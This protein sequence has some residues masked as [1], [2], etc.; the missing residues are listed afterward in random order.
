MFIAPLLAAATG[1]ILDNL[2]GSARET[3]EQFGVNAPLFLS[4]VISFLIVCVLLQRFAYR[5][6]L[7]VLEM[8]RQRIA[9]SMENAGKIQEQLADAE[10]KH[11][12]ILDRAN[13]EAQKMINEAREAANALAATREQQAIAEAEGIIAQAREAMRLE[14]DRMLADLRREVARLVVTTTG[15]VTGK[16]LT[17]DDQRRLSEEAAREIA[18]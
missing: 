18:A 10:A 5:P 17:T 14:H 6:I 9:E 3:G 16:V 15:K 2:L 4:N 13:G 7:D 8:R 12:E 1:G 11:A